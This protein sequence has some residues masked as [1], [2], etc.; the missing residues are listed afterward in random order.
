MNEQPSREDQLQ[1]AQDMLLA[2]MNQRNAAQN[3]CVQLAAQ[4]IAL[5][6][7]ITALESPAEPEAVGPHLEVVR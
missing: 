7:K 3:E 2:V 4:L 1:I 6:R 5:Q